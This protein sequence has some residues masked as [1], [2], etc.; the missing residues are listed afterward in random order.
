M[1][2]STLSVS[3]ENYPFI[4]YP[5]GTHFNRIS[6]IY[7][8]I[9]LPPPFL[10]PKNLLAED[11]RNLKEMQGSIYHLLYIG[12]TNNFYTRLKQHHKMPMA[13]ELGITHI[14]ILKISSGR[15]RK[16]IE[17]QLLQTHNPPLNQT[18]LFDAAP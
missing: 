1:N 8:F 17:R 6:G 13:L 9:I 12:I 7:I 11:S 5:L 16:K 10:H 2:L 14:G 18:W 15:K 4:L 3:I